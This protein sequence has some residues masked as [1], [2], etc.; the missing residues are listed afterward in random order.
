MAERSRVAGRIQ[1]AFTSLGELRMAAKEEVAKA[2]V[3]QD[4]AVELLLIAAIARGHVLIEGP[5]GSAKTML[6]RA[7]AH[8]LGAQFKRLQFTPDTMPDEITGRYEKKFGEI[9]FQQAR[10]SRTSCSRTRSTARLRA[11]RRCCSRR[12]RSAPSRSTARRTGSRT[13]S[14]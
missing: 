8:V 9:V 5:P 12:C 14:S 1:P 10:C 2:V 3:G 4:A 7:M 6:G 11:R 13:R